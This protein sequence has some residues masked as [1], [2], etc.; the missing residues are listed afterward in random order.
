MINKG[1]STLNLSGCTLLPADGMWGLE[2]VPSCV[3]S[4][5]GSSVLCVACVSPPTA[6]PSG[7]SLIPHAWCEMCV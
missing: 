3:T 4:V 5:V 6:R 7:R 1:P 2:T